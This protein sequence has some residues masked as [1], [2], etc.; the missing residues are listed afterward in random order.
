MA[1]PHIQDRDG[2]IQIYVRKDA[3]GEENYGIFKSWRLPRRRGE[4][5]RT[6]M[7]ELLSRLLISRT[8]LNP[9]PIALKFH[10]LSDV[11]TS[12]VNVTSIW[13]LAVKAPDRFVTFQK[14]SFLKSVATS[15]L[16]G[17]LKSE[18]PV[19]HNEAGG[20]AA[21][22]S[23]LTTMQNIDMV[24]RIATELQQTSHCWY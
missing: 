7:G 20:A 24:L 1:S 11:E 13:F 14:K 15:M 2:Q 4:V 12:T 22:L 3:V 9:S 21:S 10:G 5:M 6:D 8:C 16:K 19:L 23:S 17:F 18:T